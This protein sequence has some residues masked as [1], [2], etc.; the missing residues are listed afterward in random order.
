MAQTATA[1]SPP[2]SEKPFQIGS[3]NQVVCTDPVAVA[4][5]SRSVKTEPRAPRT[6]Y[7]RRSSALEKRCGFFHPKSAVLWSVRPTIARSLPRDP[8]TPCQTPHPKQCNH[9]RINFSPVGSHLLSWSVQQQHTERRVSNHETSVR[10]HCGCVPRRSPSALTLDC[11]PLES[12][13]LSEERS[14]NSSSSN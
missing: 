8:R 4:R 14:S 11:P 12:T 13:L 7:F 2:T 9:V 1:S 6:L 5:L 10:L 3:R